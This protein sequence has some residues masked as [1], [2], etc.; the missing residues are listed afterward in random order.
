M[1]LH[2]Q[3]TKTK[4]KTHSIDEKMVQPNTI[5]LRLEK[6]SK[7]E[8]SLFTID[9]TQKTHRNI[10]APKRQSSVVRAGMAQHGDKE[11]MHTHTAGD[12]DYWYLEKGCCYEFVANQYIEMAEGELA[13][14][15]GRSTFNRNGVLILSSIYDSGFKDF[16]G[17][18]CYNIAGDTKVRKGTRFAHLIIGSAETL[19]MYDGDYGDN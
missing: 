7:I 11:T 5:D 6:V 14:I 13:I 2:P 19:N 3:S 16:I 15:I 9:E 1:F 8:P 18:T 12:D 10:V 17:A 4:T